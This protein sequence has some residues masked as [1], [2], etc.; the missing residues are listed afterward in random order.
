MAFWEGGFAESGVARTLIILSALAVLAGCG[1]TQDAKTAPAVE[2]LRWSLVLKAPP[3]MNTLAVGKDGMIYVGATD[4]RVYAID[5]AGREKW[6]KDLDN[7]VMG[8][9][10]TGPSGDIYITTYGAQEVPPRASQA[11]VPGFEHLYVFDKNGRTRADV[12]VNGAGPIAVGKDGAV[13]FRGWS[14][15]GNDGVLYAYDP[16]GHQK[17]S[18]KVDGI[19]GVVQTGKDGGV[20]MAVGPGSMNAKVIALT[21]EGQ[22]RWKFLLGPEENAGSLV[23][24]EDIVYI[25]C[26]NRYGYGRFLRAL[27]SG[28][29]FLWEH[30][31]SG[32]IISVAADKGD[33]AVMVGAE[34]AGDPAARGS[35]V[36]TARAY[37]SGGF[38]KWTREFTEDQ[39]HRT[40]SLNVGQDGTVYFTEDVLAGSTWGLFALTRKGDLKWKV[41]ARAPLANDG[42]LHL[43]SIGPDDQEATFV[44]LDS[45]G[46][47]RWDYT[48]SAPVNNTP[49]IGLDGTLFIGGNAKLY[50]LLAW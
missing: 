44:S 34:D 1:S 45:N 26:G 40:G 11:V 36:L 50:A 4:K 31:S 27:S 17:W 19:L 48:V 2:K 15:L 29:K 32:R 49:V 41:Q 25:V 16:D 42:L 46:D 9:I 13:Y 24:G 28:G 20:Y 5:K 6:E 30:E 37:D 43:G 3:I 39:G 22:E 10:A 14:S 38:L 23:G 35:E 7:L 33:T 12:A 8:P 47:K 21:A 18:F